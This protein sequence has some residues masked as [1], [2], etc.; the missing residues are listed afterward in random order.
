MSIESLKQ[1]F[2]NNNDIISRLIWANIIVFAI[3]WFFGSMLTLFE[4]NGVGSQ[5]YKLLAIPSD[6]GAFITRP[7]TIFT[8]M[9]FK[10]RINDWITII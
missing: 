9:F 6:L 3:D 4:V 7:W 8:Y 5:I 2:F 10:I 1:K